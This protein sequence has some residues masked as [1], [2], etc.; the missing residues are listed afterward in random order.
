MPSASKNCG[1]FN[2]VELEYIPKLHVVFVLAP[3]TIDIVV[4]VHG[5]LIKMGVNNAPL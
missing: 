3:P 2:E 4:K 5:L 1:T